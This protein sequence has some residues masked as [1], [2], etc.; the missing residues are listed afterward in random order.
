MI[1]KFNA[2]GPK[3]KELAGLISRFT[4]NECRYLGA[5]GFSYEIGR[6]VVDRNGN[7]QTDYEPG[8]ETVELLTEMLYDNGFVTEYDES[9]GYDLEVSVPR[10]TLTD[11]HIENL[12]KLI[13][14]EAELIKK[15]LGAEE[16]PVVI[17]DERIIFPWF[18]KADPATA[19]TYTVFIT[20]LCALA[21]NAVRI[22]DSGKPVENEKYAFRCF[23]LRLGFIGEE[24]KTDRRIL[25]KNLEGSSA[26]KRPRAKEEEPCSD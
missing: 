7:V 25:L 17:T 14:K 11:A 8:S 23:L 12:R 15:A 26:F 24:Y 22:N 5:P 6:F 2:R 9:G 4:G 1:L 19:G 3:R 16:L 13:A 10:E 21:K 18:G 20:K